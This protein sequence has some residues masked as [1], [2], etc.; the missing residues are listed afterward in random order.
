[1]QKKKS[2]RNVDHP[3]A[4]FISNNEPVREGYAA[5]SGSSG[6]LFRET[7]E[8]YNTSDLRFSGASGSNENE[9]KSKRLNLLIRPSLMKNF[10]K[11]AY[12]RRTSINDLINRLIDD[13]VKKDA[14]MVEE[15]DKLFKD[16]PQ[17]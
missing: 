17:H 11:I 10:M 4:A 16:R 8:E 3:A 5:G 9:T 1:M 15:Y 12:M 13:C 2:F 6:S 14:A 7:R